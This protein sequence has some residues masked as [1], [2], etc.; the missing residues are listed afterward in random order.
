[1][2]A[3]GRVVPLQ[4][5]DQTGQLRAQKPHNH[6]RCQSDGHGQSHGAHRKGSVG[7]GQLVLG[8]VQ[9]LLV[10]YA[11]VTGAAHGFDAD[12]L[13]KFAVVEPVVVASKKEHVSHRLGNIRR[14]IPVDSMPFRPFDSWSRFVAASSMV[15][16]KVLLE[17]PTVTEAIPPS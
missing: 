17:I 6:H 15:F 4:R 12:H 3:Q 8:V 14:L 9:S 13:S 11:V 7:H 16:I 10:D 1:M 5:V 2:F